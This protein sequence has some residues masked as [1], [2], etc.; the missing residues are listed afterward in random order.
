MIKIKKLSEPSILS[1]NKNKW[2]EEYKNWLNDQDVPES[3]KRQYSKDEIKQRLTKE[4]GEKCAY[5]ESK[6]NHVS[7]ANIEH[8][9]PK[10]KYPDHFATWENL[11]IACK[12]CNVNKGD[13]YNEN[14]PPINPYQDEPS[15]HFNAAG[16]MILTTTPRGKYTEQLLGLNRS[17]LIERRTE[18]INNIHTLVQNLNGD[19]TSAECVA[20]LKE[21]ENQIDEKSEYCFIV[22]KFVLEN[23][24]LNLDNYCQSAS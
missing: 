1:D 6:M 7:Y 5:C 8:I 22:K 10:S 20:L 19:I 12:R 11:T 14:C 21:I 13:R 2:A 17:E 4:T 9:K 3:V 23:Q 18:K 15:A 24:D 16:P